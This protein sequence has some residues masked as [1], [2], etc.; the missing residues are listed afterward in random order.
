MKVVLYV[1]CSTLDQDHEVQLVELRAYA[2]REGWEIAQEYVDRGFSG[3]KERRPALDQL[4]ADARLR[5][6]QA[7]LVQRFDRFGRSL[8]HLIQC[9][10]EFRAR[11]I[12][13]ISISEAFDTTTATGELLFHVAGAFAQFERNLIRERV[14]AGIAHAKAKGVRLGRPRTLLDSEKITVLRR[15]GFSISQIA[16]KAHCSRST[17]RRVLKI[18]QTQLPLPETSGQNF[19]TPSEAGLPTENPTD[20]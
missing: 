19:G 11:K 15:E 18:N 10:E 1:R 13:F 20:G 16:E 6:F 3:A 14:K 17:I 4:M 2:Q 12:A 8:K 7:V 5:R 9:L